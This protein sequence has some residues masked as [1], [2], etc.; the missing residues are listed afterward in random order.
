MQTV[1]YTSSSNCAHTNYIDNDAPPQRS[2]HVMWTK[3]N[4]ERV[5]YDELSAKG[6]DLFYPKIDQW[7]ASK[8]GKYLA[9]VPM[10]RGYLFI[11]HAIGRFDYIDI[12]GAKGLVSILGDR[13]DRLAIIPDQQINDIRNICDGEVPVSAHS[14]LNK[15]DRVRVTRGSLKDTQ[16]ILLKKDHQ[17]GLLI[18]TVSLLNRSIAVEVNCTDVVPV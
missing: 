14:F 3:S 15:G 8:T 13:W 5:V 6:Y 2:W 4:C 9:S 16:G 11:N 17:T 1:S 12:C 18:V 7:I 10:F